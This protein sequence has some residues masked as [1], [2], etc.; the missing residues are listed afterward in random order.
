MTL[1]VRLEN[2]RCHKRTTCLER[3][4][5]PNHQRLL[6]YAEV[7]TGL[8]VQKTRM[9]PDY[10]YSSIPIPTLMT[11]MFYYYAQ[12]FMYRIAF[13]LFCELCIELLSIF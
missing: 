6:S 11:S 4:K 9:N 13:G 10:F 2:D 12:K 7:S 8:D 3:N 5:M 1:D